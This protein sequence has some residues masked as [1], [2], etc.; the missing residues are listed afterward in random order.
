MSNTRDVAQATQTTPAAHAYL[1]PVPTNQRG[2]AF[3][4]LV[5][6][7]RLRRRMTQE[8]LEAA[9]GVS[10]STIARWEAGLAS[11]P[12]PDGVRAVCAA[13]GEDARLAAVALGYLTDD[14]LAASPTEPLDPDVRRWMA[15]LADPDVPAGQKEVMRAQMQNWADQIQAFKQGPSQAANH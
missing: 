8:Q 11:T 7:A 9:T 15:I 1:Q 3:G 5:R 14:E 2:E 12:D 13:L 10:R 4:K 6:D